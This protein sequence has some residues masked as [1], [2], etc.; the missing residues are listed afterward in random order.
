MDTVKVTVLSG[1][2]GGARFLRGLRSHLRDERPDARIT[3]IVNTG[4]DMWLTGLRIAPDLDSIMYT[5]AGENDEARG[6]GRI[7]E[8]ERVSGELRAYGVGWPWFTLGDLDI[9]THIARSHY[10]RSGLPLSEATARIASRWPLGVRLIPATDDEVETH[11]VTDEG[12]LHFQEWWTRH[13]AA[14]PA[15]RFVQVGVE[16]ASP[17]PGVLE[18]I[19]AADV[20]L[21]APSNP[22]VS[23]GTILGIPGIRE[24][25]AAASG[26]VIGV[27]P[28]I[29]GAVVRGMADACL[30][31]IGVATS[32]LAVARH[33]GSRASGGVLDAW[34]VDE[35]DAA[36]V[37]GI[38]AIGI[39]SAA[40]PLWMR[41]P[42]TSAQL[43]KDALALAR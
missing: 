5:L 16:S 41:D 24:A 28:I 7:G 10:L 42:A 23:I 30:E 37:P 13:R 18:A 22:V 15:R 29:A 39:R 31:A 19:A 11:V 17:A 14:L 43:A 12:E 36:S 27:S 2:V 21:F 3:T 20:V 34:L 1:G 9:G 32:A 38:E 35:S 8:T 25:V 4:D 40:A 26:T 6:W 33:Y